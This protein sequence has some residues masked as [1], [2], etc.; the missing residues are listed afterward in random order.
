M[1]PYHA[2]FN[3]VAMR[4]LYVGKADLKLLDSSNPPAWSSQSAGITASWLSLLA[5]EV[6]TAIT[7]ALELGEALS[8]NSKRET[9]FWQLLLKLWP[10]WSL[11]LSPRLEYSGVIS[12][13]SL[14]LPG[15]SSSPASASRVAGITGMCHHSQLTF[16]G[17]LVET[18]SHDVGQ[19]GFQLLTSSDPPPQPL[20]VLGLQALSHALSSR[21]EYSDTVIETKSHY[22]TQV[23]LKLLASSNPSTLAFQSAG[24]TDGVLLCHQ[25][26]VQ[27]R[28]LGSLQPPPPGFKRFFR[29]SLLSSG[30]H[31]CVPPRPANFVFLVETGFH[32]VGR[33][34]LDLLTSR[35][36]RLGLPKVSAERS[37]V[38]RM[39]FPLWVTRTFSLAALSIFSFISTLKILIIHL[40][41]PDSVSSSHSSSV[42]PCS[43][44]DE[45]LRSPSSALPIAVLL[46]GMGPA[47]PDQKGTTQSHTLRTEKR[48]TGQK[49]RAGDLRGSLTGNLPV[50]GHQIFICNCGVHWLSAPSPRAT[51][52]SY[53]YAAILDLSPPGDEFFLF[54]SFPLADAGSPL[55]GFAAPAV[56]L[57]VLSASNCCFPCG[58]GTSRARP[59]RTLRT[60]KRRAGCRQNS[61]AGQ[62]SRWR[63]AWLLRWESPGLWATKTRRKTGS[64]CFTQAGLEL[65]ASSHPYTVASQNDGFSLLLPRLEC[66]GT[67]LAHCN[68][69]FPGSSDSPP[70]ASQIAEITGTCH[71]AQLIFCIFSRDGVS[72][73]WPGWSRTPDI[74][75]Q[76]NDTILTHC[77]LCLLG[78]SN[79]PN[80]ASLVAGTTG[81]HHHAQII[82]V[83]LVETGF[84]R[85]AQAGL[86]LLSSGCHSVPSRE[87]HGMI[88][89]HCSLDPLGP[90]DP[91]TSTSQVAGTTGTCHHAHLILLL[92]YVETGSFYVSQAGL[93]LLGS[94]NSPT[95]AS[96][97]TGITGMSHHA[98][99]F[100]LFLMPE[101]SSTILAHCSLCHR[102]PTI[103]LPQPS[104]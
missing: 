54:L 66:N 81:M 89:A 27:W 59:S 3:F 103:L 62:E 84:H 11:T 57:S 32:H 52:P 96:M 85:V 104:E 10:R 83:F 1:P 43:L 77:N 22:V 73:C 9:C 38:S 90:G 64:C 97:S 74:K 71:H 60:G 21:W 28:N 101:C 30:D 16:F 100:S 80:S 63:P 7:V 19:A 13:C 56:K 55:P 2:H 15:S 25:A 46:V 36:T 86:K 92:L 8:S 17:F 65:L 31:R 78:S 53:C 45:E 88:M 44:A 18:G 99:P 95:L 48:R 42:K 93:E 67:T 82:F 23:A 4:S 87:C 47:A 94:S 12:H 40:L 20:K 34:G 91:S 51:I 6:L 29:L 75:L 26:G 58:D 98:W 70:L 61:H 37:A 69:H 50:R 102:V 68:L 24:I 39:G 5:P 41:K 35:S 76:C 49:S 79:P 72:P 33:D 14:C